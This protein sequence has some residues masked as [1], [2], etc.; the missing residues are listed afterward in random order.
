MPLLNEAGRPSTGQMCWVFFVLRGFGTLPVYGFSTGFWGLSGL[1]KQ[2]VCC[3]F[4]SFHQNG[5]GG[6][7]IKRVVWGRFV[8]VWAIH[9]LP[10]PWFGMGR[11]DFGVF[12]RSGRSNLAFVR[13]AAGVGA[14]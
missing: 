1:R 5:G 13:R 7:A 2:A 11:M 9:A 14:G 10:M 6:C 4:S 8:T 12:T 3:I